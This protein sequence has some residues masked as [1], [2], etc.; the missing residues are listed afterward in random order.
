MSCGKFPLFLLLLSTGPTLAADIGKPITDV[1]LHGVD[2]KTIQLRD[3]K[4][5]SAIVVVF[6][7]F[8][9][10]VSNSYAP[11]LNELAKT[12]GPRKVAVL[13]IAPTDDAAAELA[14]QA[15]E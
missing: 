12:Y 7:S 5:H 2:G 4:D 1:R 11:V 13:A 10:P 14:K 15:K 3:L 6:L 8:E 9:C